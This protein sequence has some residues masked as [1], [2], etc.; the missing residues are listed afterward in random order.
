MKYAAL[1]FLLLTT[2][3]VDKNAKEPA[4]GLS[5]KINIIMTPEHWDSPI[6]KSLDSIFSQEMTVLPR[7]ETIF[8]IRHVDPENVN[9]SM[10]RTRNLLFV[11]TLDDPSIKSEKIKRMLTAETINQMKKDTSV[12]MRTLPNVYANGQEVMYLFGPD[13]KALATDRK[14]VV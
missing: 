13:E 2:A 3:C 9:S 10:K 5:G 8:K 14:S 11:F 12:F 1:T 4:I 7:P 6:G